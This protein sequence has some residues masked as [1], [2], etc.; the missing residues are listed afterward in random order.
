MVEEVKKLEE[1]AKEDKPKK[2]EPKDKLVKLIL[3]ND[4]SA[5]VEVSNYM[6]HWKAPTLMQQ[7][8]IQIKARNLV[9]GLEREDM[10]ILYVADAIATLDTVID[11]II[12]KKKD[13]AQVEVKGGFWEYFGKKVSPRIISDIIVPL[14]QEYVEF[15]KQIDIEEIDLKNS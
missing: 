13:G 8:Q 4:Y 12:V 14:Y 15:E 10:G 5:A 6:F 3:G 2:E 9:K 1:V 11:K 7:M